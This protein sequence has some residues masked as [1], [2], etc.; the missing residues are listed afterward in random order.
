MNPPALR[1]KPVHHG[2]VVMLSDGRVLA[3]FTGVRAKRRALRYLA[4]HDVITDAA[5]VR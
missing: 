4:S 5:D 1:L 2:W 3:Q